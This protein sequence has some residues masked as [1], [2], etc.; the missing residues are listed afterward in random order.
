M[1]STHK[2]DNF[3][4]PIP[5]VLETTKLRLVPFVP[6]I[7]APLILQSTT[8]ATWHYLPFGPFPTAEAL[9]E[10]FYEARIH[11]NRGDT[12]FVGYDLTG[13]TKTNDEEGE[14]GV[15]DGDRGGGA[16]GDKGDNN[17]DEG[18]PAGICGYVYTNPSDLYTELFVLA[19]PRYH[20]THVA[21]HM[22]GLLMRYALDLPS[23]SPPSPGPSPTSLGG[24][25]IGGSGVGGSGG[26]GSG[27]PGGLGL[28]RVQW[29]ANV[30]NHGSIGLARKMGFRV[31]GVRRWARVLDS[32]KG[33]G[34]NGEGGAGNGE[35][36][37][38][39]GE[40]G[41]G[42]GEGGAGNGIK[43]RKGDPREECPGRDTVG[44]AI[45]W[46]EWEEGGRER[47]EGILGV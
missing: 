12:L 1:L 26:G 23:P 2:D 14:G 25:G 8:T 33:E 5:D 20:H 46:D 6:S 47:V 24:D 17:N 40:A 18:T 9:V 34:G 39:N 22:I 42:N 31:E 11:R 45:C 35:G 15:D 32:D 13:Q 44:L 37:A 10:D 29:S 27:G 43:R 4:Y 38:G 16:E 21:S 3:C 41:A 28:R 30:H 19:F 7:H 36:G